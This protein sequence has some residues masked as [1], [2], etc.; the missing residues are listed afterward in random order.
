MIIIIIAATAYSLFCC[1][2]VM[3]CREESKL[4]CA[5]MGSPA[6]ISNTPEGSTATQTPT[7]YNKAAEEADIQK[8][9]LPFRINSDV[10]KRLYIFEG[11]ICAL[12]TDCLMCFTT[13]GLSGSDELAARLLACGL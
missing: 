1:L 7:N 12:K 9:P 2:L 5:N 10:N 3:E 4:S 8:D 13:D 11:D 6:N